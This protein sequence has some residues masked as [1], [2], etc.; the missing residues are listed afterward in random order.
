MEEGPLNLSPQKI[1]G[2]GAPFLDYILK[3]SDA[4]LDKLPGSKEGMMHVDYLTFS[5]ILNTCGVKPVLVPGGSACNTI[6]GL[7][8]LG[9]ACAFVGKVG[10]DEA[11]E[12]VWNEL[13]ELKIRPYFSQSKNPSAQVLCLVAPN[14]SR[15]FRS[16][17]GAGL[18]M[19]S[20]DL[21]PDFFQDQ[22]LVHI[23]G[24]SLHNGAYT[25]KAMQLAKAS[26]AKV[27]F[28]LSSP[29][30]V[31]QFHESIWKLI[32]EHVDILFANENEIRALTQLGSQEGC[33]LLRSI[34]EVAV[35]YMNV[36]GCWVGDRSGQERYPA[37]PV[38]PFDTTG[39]GD[40]SASGFLHGYL[41]GASWERCAHF[42]ALLGAQ[43]VQVYGAE[44]PS[45]RW[46]ALY[47]QIPR[48]E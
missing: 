1:L 10:Q 35:V 16:F 31:L 4:F 43:V 44:I 45:D 9:H 36:K 19:T 12:I 18:E 46:D 39:A 11:G 41:M 30:V 27:S 14:G 38:T 47:H 42:G 13:E 6:R 15:T 33:E 37:Y 3:V 22:K 7:A 32:K 23:E 8:R 34:V 48:V 20:R 26:G 17:G 40:L 2:V 28:D 5:H 21:E 25:E 29:E 24:Y